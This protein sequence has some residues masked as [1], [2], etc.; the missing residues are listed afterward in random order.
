[1]M[2][3]LV[4]VMVMVMMVMMAYVMMD[5]QKWQ[6]HTTN[7]ELRSLKIP[8]QSISCHKWSPPIHPIHVLPN[9]PLT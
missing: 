1:M 4:M 8:F 2:M 6:C 9:V 5:F 3:V 7:L